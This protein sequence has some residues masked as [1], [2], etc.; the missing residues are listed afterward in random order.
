MEEIENVEAENFSDKEIMNRIT[1]KLELK[2]YKYREL[3]GLLGENVI[4]SKN[5][6]GKKSQLKRWQR[7]FEFVKKGHSIIITKIYDTP[8]IKAENRGG[9]K[10][11]KY[12]DDLQDALVDYFYKAKIGDREIPFSLEPTRIM[13]IIGMINPNYHWGNKYR[14]ELSFYLKMDKKIIDDFYTNSYGEFTKIIENAFNKLEEKEIFHWAKTYSVIFRS[15]NNQFLEHKMLD[16][17]EI[18]YLKE[19]EENIMEDMGFNKIF[20]VIQNGKMLD[21]KT[22]VI[23]KINSN[24]KDGESKIRSYSKFYKFLVVNRNIEIEY[25]NI[26]KRREQL[27]ITT[28]KRIKDKVEDIY[29]NYIEDKSNIAREDYKLGNEVLIKHLFDLFEYDM[30]MNGILE[31]YRNLWTKKKLY[32]PSRF[33]AKIAK[34]KYVTKKKR[35][36]IQEQKEFEAERDALG[37]PEEWEELVR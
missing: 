27:N 5:S 12:L 9:R 34:V 7:F 35:K 17:S 32:L 30:K 11:F 26:V 36:E 3:C 18:K 15:T 22:R 4:D 8:I 29:D 6:H 10:P 19:I 37:T 1:N 21:F 25:V 2:S 13:E 31:E 20:Q 23:T 33:N 14:D 24:K 16:K 28:T